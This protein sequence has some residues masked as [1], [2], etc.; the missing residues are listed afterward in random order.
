MS[1][2]KNSKYSLV[3]VFIC[4]LTLTI[5]SFL[6]TYLQHSYCSSSATSF[7]ASLRMLQ[8]QWALFMGPSQLKTCECLSSWLFLT[9]HIED[10]HFPKSNFLK[11]HEFSRFAF[12][13]FSVAM[14]CS[15]AWQRCGGRWQQTGGMEV[16]AAACAD[17]WRCRLTCLWSKSWL[18]WASLWFL[19]G[20]G[21]SRGWHSLL[22]DKDRYW[23]FA[24]ELCCCL[25][26][27]WIYF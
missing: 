17:R 26:L 6:N 15:V 8:W 2:C 14:S 11:T 12:M 13:S 9:L 21:W 18:A 1:R 20:Y 5:L 22:F 25:L 3:C 10:C 4:M 19:W 16:L 7:S 23:E 27:F 24:T